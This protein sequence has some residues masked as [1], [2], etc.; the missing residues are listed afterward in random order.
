MVCPGQCCPFRIATACR[1][2]RG[3]SSPRGTQHPLELLAPLGNP[4]SR[5]APHRRRGLERPV[6]S[7]RI[8]LAQSI[9][10]RTEPLRAQSTRARSRSRNRRA[11]LRFFGSAGTHRG[12][13]RRLCRSRRY[14]VWTGKTA[15]RISVRSYA[16]T[17]APVDR[18]RPLSTFGRRCASQSRPRSGTAAAAGARSRKTAG[19][20]DLADCRSSQYRITTC[21]GP[22]AKDH[23]R[24][25][26]ESPRNSFV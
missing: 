8:A 17:G 10:G 3:R 21:D 6:G 2:G 1:C 12:H 25:G 4:R 18:A 26:A 15:A 24:A 16:C 19:P 22:P 23:W 14:S 5:G 9:A 13:T 11:A 20:P 7:D